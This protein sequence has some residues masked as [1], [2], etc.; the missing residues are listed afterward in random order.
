MG[1]DLRILLRH[2]DGQ[3][4]I[5]LLKLGNRADVVEVAV[6]EENRLGNQ[7]MLGEGGENAVRLLSG[8]DDQ[9]LLPFD[10]KRAVDFEGTDLQGD[11]FHGVFL[12]FSFSS[13]ATAFLA[14]AKARVRL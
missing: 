10:E 7:V 9:R 12:S 13:A 6:R 11:A 1:Q 5:G 14:V 3:F 8:I 4:G 2:I